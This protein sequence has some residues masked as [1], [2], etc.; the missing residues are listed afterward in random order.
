MT[1][2]FCY[3]SQIPATH[4]ALPGHFPGSPVVPG[5]VLLNLVGTAFQHWRTDCGKTPA[6]IAGWPLVKFIVPVRP[7]DKVDIEFGETAPGTLKFFIR[8]AEHL[9]VSGVLS[10]A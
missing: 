8:V 4:A 6:R 9:V 10:Y 3:S 7:A 1:P 5:V 2:A